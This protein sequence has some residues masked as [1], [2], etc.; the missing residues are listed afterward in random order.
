M[1]KAYVIRHAIRAIYISLVSIFS[2]NIIFYAAVLTNITGLFP[3]SFYHDTTI[4]NAKIKAI[5]LLILLLSATAVYL[6]AEYAIYSK[7]A[8]CSNETAIWTPPRKYLLLMSYLYFIIFSF[9]NFLVTLHFI[10]KNIFEIRT[11]GWGRTKLT[12]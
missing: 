9:L 8:A 2:I 10:S 1:K 11:E 6:I 5:N 3:A 12:C 7:I 4:H